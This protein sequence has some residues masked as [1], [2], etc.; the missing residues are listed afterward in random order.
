MMRAIDRPGRVR[1]ESSQRANTVVQRCRRGSSAAPL[2]RSTEPR[3]RSS[4]AAR[5]VYT[6]A[7]AGDLARVKPPPPIA[8]GRLEREQSL[9]RAAGSSAP[10]PARQDPHLERRCASGQV[11]SLDA[12]RGPWGH[13]QVP[14]RLR[15]MHAERAT[16]SCPRRG[17]AAH[18]PAHGSPPR[19]RRLH[20]ARPPRCARRRDGG[21]ARGSLQEIATDNGSVWGSPATFMG[22]RSADHTFAIRREADRDP[23]QSNNQLPNLGTPP[24]SSVLRTRR[25]WPS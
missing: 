4:L 5:G 2:R 14:P 23:L 10:A 13:G 24:R 6:L 8:P 12:I 16:R 11:D 19:P 20:G 15:A 25:S 1:R 3:A 17:P 22:L 18:D 9:E 7:S 21:P